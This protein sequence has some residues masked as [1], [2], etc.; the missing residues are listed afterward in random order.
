MRSPLT[1]SVKR[2]TASS[3]VRRL[4]A[5]FILSLAG[6]ARAAVAGEDDGEA[7]V[8]ASG[9]VVLGWTQDVH[10]ESPDSHGRMQ[11]LVHEKSR[12]VEP[13]D[14]F[15]LGVHYWSRPGTSIGAQFEV[16]DWRNSLDVSHRPAAVR[17]FREK[18]TAFLA[19]V[20]GRISLSSVS[21][22]YLYGGIGGGPAVSRLRGSRKQVGPALSL[23]SGICVPAAHS[24]L[25]ACVESQYWITRDFNALVADRGNTQQLRFSGHPSS[26][27]ARPIFGPHQDSRFAAVVLG[28]RWSRARPPQRG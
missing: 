11:E 25:T 13:G 20:T 16:A 19:N 4:A 27:T 7:S 14:V 26:Y 3:A 24:R 9:G 21:Q 28:L 6:A 15:G 8:G 18:H 1:D 22:S 10:V 2:K 17:R 12:S 23:L 5:L